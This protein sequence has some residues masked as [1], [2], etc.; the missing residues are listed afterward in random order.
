M[1]T[2][3]LNTFVQA[4]RLGGRVVVNEKTPEPTVTVASQGFKGRLYACLSQ[5]PLLKNLEAVKAIAS[6]YRLK[7]KPLW[8]SSS[9]RCPGVMA[10][11]APKRRWTAWA[12]SR[13]R[14]S[15]SGWWS[16]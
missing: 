16:N 10:R 14:R 6:A 9:T 2:L 12:G 7:T 5:L 4:A 15:S 1:T 3:N 13:A 11:K 8:A